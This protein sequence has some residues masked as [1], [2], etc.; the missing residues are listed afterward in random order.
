VRRGRYRARRNYDR[1]APLYDLLA[2]PFERRGRRIGRHLLDIRPGERVLEVGCGTGADLA[3]LATATGPRGWCLGLDLSE[4][5]VRRTDQRLT[6]REVTERATVAQADAVQLPL[7]P[8]CFDAVYLSF[9][10]ELFDADDLI[11]VLQ[12]CARVLQP[13]GRLGVVSLAMTDDPPLMT[14]L[15]LR[16]HRRYPS[17]LDC[18]PIPTDQL[19]ARSGFTVL[20]R[21]RPSMWG[22]PVDVIVARPTTR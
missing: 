16:A 19:L 20:V 17:L 9:T 15:Y 14:R 5:M 13:T 2:E 7:A 21:R 4:R 11:A 1:L 8:R 12:E 22:L 3:A 18:R 6:R 10:L